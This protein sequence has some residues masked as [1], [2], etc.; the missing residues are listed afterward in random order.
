[1]EQQNVAWDG[2]EPV[3]C[4]VATTVAQQGSSV[5]LTI[6]KAQKKRLLT[7]KINNDS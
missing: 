7:I 4:R 3:M 6:H 5:S 1:M 2:Q